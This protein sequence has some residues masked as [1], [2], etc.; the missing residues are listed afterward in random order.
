MPC[1]AAHGCATIEPMSDQP[2][3]RPIVART[4][5]QQSI[6]GV[7]YAI[8]EWGAADAPLLIYVH[9]W[10]DCGSTF[11]FVVDALQREWHVVA[12]D[13]RGFGRSTVD[14]SSYWFPDYLADLHALGEQLSPS[15]PLRLIGHSMGGNVSSL[16]AG[17]KPERVSSLVNIE[18]LG[19]P[20]SDP[21]DAP[22]RYRE[23]IEQQSAPQEFSNYRDFD[24]LA[25]RVRK[26]N[27]RMS[28]AAA[29]FVA[30]EWAYEGTDGV[31]RLR[32]DPRHKLPNPVL[33]QRAAA[34][35]CW[36][37]VTADVLLVSGVQ[38]R[39]MLDYG[40]AADDMFPHARR[41]VIDD[42]GHM[43]H[44]EAPAVLAATIEQFLLP[45]L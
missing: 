39:L 41:A 18:G 5:R 1:T 3:Y 29:A 14:C 37:Q 8:H 21:N 38:S 17:I 45:T 11:Q 4:T 9:G 23:W 25:H 22:Q 35:A 10:G 34:A 19:M 33:Y 36:R 26:R 44:F 40:A 28:A 12:P 16:Y 43:L 42:A 2:V 6:R 24:A 32:A 15:E 13:W 31:V 7:N 27:P 30:R 20:D